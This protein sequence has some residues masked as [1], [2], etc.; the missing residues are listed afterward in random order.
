VCSDQKRNILFTPCGHVTVCSGCSSRVKKCLLCKEFVDDRR[1][2]GDC[3]VCTDNPAQVL[4]KPCNHMVACASCAPFMK[5]CVEC[6]E[7]IENKIAFNVC[8]G[9][10]DDNLEKADD[11]SETTVD[12]SGSSTTLPA[13]TNNTSINNSLG[14]NTGAPKTRN[15]ESV[16][17]EEKTKDASMRDV[18]KLQQQL[19]DIKEQTMCPVCLDRLKNMIF[20]CGHGTCQM[21]GDR[22]SECPI[23]RKPVERRILLY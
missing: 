7:N 14:H 8:C 6:R 9:G 19:A 10:K 17:S 22:M 20:L 11:N 13:S 4:F 5:R 16:P 18:Q 21:C 3:T 12:I 1:P 15:K 23:C 2:I